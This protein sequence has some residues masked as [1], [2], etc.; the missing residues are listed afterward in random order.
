MTKNILHS[1]L[2]GKDIRQEDFAVPKCGRP[3]SIT[4]YMNEKLIE[5]E[6]TKGITIS[7]NNFVLYLYLFFWFL[8]IQ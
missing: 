5:A 4:P 7:I 8:F 1:F 2:S 3:K 6:E